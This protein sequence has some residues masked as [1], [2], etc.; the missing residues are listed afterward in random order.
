[1]TKSP[2]ESI[3]EKKMLWS[4]WRASQNHFYIKTKIC[5]FSLLYLFD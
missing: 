4:V 5:D 1:M 2:E 3:P